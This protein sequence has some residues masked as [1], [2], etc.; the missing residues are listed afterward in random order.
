MPFG[1]SGPIQ[2]VLILGTLYIGRGFADND[3][4]CIV[5]TYDTSAGKWATLPPY[6]T[7]SRY[8]AM[9]TINHHLVLVGG[10]KRDSYCKGLGVWRA[11]SQTWTTPYPDMT[12]PR[13]RCST[14]VYTKY[15]VVAGGRG[16][17]GRL[18]SVEVMDTD[19]NEWYAVPPTPVAWTEMKTA[20]VG[21]MCYFMG[22]AIE[23][24]HTNKV[25]SVSLPAL[26]S[27][28]V[29]FVDEKRNQP[30]KEL[31]Q[32]ENNIIHA[33]PLSIG[34]SLLAVG[35]MNKSTTVSAFHLYQPN[36]G[37]WVKVADM[38][39]ADPA[40]VFLVHVNHPF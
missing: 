15:L 26:V 6:S 35:G 27:R 1:M 3:I 25:F 13:A 17:D 22:G 40:V 2:S 18:S 36:A 30:W 31:P 4:D 11:D 39:V 5:M 38:S 7:V 21:D 20:K 24:R 8:F 16:A 33:A 32:L 28:Q 34:G 12:T 14:V 10:W 19:C 29:S 37:Q 9:N 23:G